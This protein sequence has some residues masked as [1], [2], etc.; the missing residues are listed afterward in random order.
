MIKKVENNIIKI[1]IIKY[2]KLILLFKKKAKDYY[3]S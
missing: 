2:L 3:S 1:V